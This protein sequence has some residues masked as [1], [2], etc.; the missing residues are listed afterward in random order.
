ME[1]AEPQPRIDLLQIPPAQAGGE[2]THVRV[3]SC[4][5]TLGVP[6]E[7]GIMG[8]AQLCLLTS[9]LYDQYLQLLIFLARQKAPTSCLEENDIP[10]HQLLPLP[11]QPG[12]HTCLEENLGAGEEGAGEASVQPKCL[13][14]PLETHLSSQDTAAA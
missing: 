4:P 5:S 6:L 13:R 10:R 14:V 9:N 11:L 8:D 7:W 2:V 12:D 3:S 1:K